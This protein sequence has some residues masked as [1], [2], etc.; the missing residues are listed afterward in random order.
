MSQNDLAFSETCCFLFLVVPFAALGGEQSKCG[1]CCESL[2]IAPLKIL[3]SAMI[4]MTDYLSSP[5]LSICL[6][7][8][9]QRRLFHIARS[10][11]LRP[12]L[13]NAAAAGTACGRPQ[14]GPTAGAE[15]SAAAPCHNF[16]WLDVAGRWNACWA[17]RD[18][19]VKAITRPPHES[20]CFLL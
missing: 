10:P 1:R 3:C 12:A 11:K 13:V 4:P 20:R 17:K 16:G 7:H 8:S 6:G 19:L 18:G 5:S 9:V 2:A 15:A 14:H